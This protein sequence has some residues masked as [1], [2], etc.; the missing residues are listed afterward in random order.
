MQDEEVINRK[1]GK[2]RYCD[3]LTASGWRLLQQARE[4]LGPSAWLTGQD[5]WLSMVVTHSDYDCSVHFSLWHGQPVREWQGITLPTTGWVMEADDDRLQLGFPWHTGA[6]GPDGLPVSLRE[7]VGPLEAWWAAELSAQGFT[8]K[9]D[10]AVR[11]E[12][13]LEV[14]WEDH[15]DYG[16]VEMTRA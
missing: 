11:G 2:Q 9:D 15:E 4:S 14:S 6:P 3:H 5:R 16:A 13:R 1:R 10:V 8:V 12:L 7:D